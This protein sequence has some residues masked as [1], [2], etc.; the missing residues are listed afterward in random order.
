[1][2]A[3]RVVSRVTYR[4]MAVVMCLLT[5]VLAS[6]STSDTAASDFAGTVDVGDGRSVFVE[7]RGEGSPTV[8]LIAGK[9]NGA[10]DW[11]QVLA[12][13]DPAHAAPGD[14]L[15]WG[16]GQ[17]QRSDDAV[18]PSV[19]GFTRVCTYDRPDV[20]IDGADLTTP[21]SQPHTLDLDVADLHAM[22]ST[23]G[24]SGPYVLVA[25][26]YGGL[27]AT[28][29]ARQSPQTIGG[30]VMVDTVTELMADVVS[31]GKLA[32]WDATNAATS[33]QSREGVELI[34]AFQRINATEPMPNVPAVVMSADKPWR[35][36]LLPPEATQG[37]QVTFTDWQTALDRQ[38]TALG[39]ERIA[40]T[41]SGHDIYLYS[42]ALV[43]EAIRDVLDQVRE[44][45]P[46]SSR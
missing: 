42:P 7:C 32:T 27:I 41:D 22:L 20:R 15:P 4:P 46:T 5:L 13:D 25:H 16:M 37:E 26:S 40:D 10:E 29:F 3:R 43:V 23:L 8:V 2:A 9:G 38:S 45:T 21:R 36:D 11:L 19:A 6:C 24:E 17:L 1:M 33:P 35:T 14:D 34:D 28:L 30:L 39:A 12:P 18:F 31:P 44:A